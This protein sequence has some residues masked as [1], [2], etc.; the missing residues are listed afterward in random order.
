MTAAGR[1]A[2]R[3]NLIVLLV[4]CTALALGSFWVL[5]V[6]RHSMQ[7]TESVPARNAPDYFVD[8]FH[9]VRMSR[10]GQ[11]EYDISGKRMTHF[12][13]D[14][15]N[16]VQSPVV[17]SLASDRSPMSIQAQRAV[18][19]QNSSK[20]HL[21]DNVQLD[22]PATATSEHFHLTTDYLLLLPDD[23]IAKTDKPVDMTLGAARLKGIGMLANNA[24]SQLSLYGDVHA[25]YP[26]KGIATR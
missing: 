4:V 12:P 17:H 13:G 23:D 7:D 21:Y 15:T 24:T 9:Y 10:T 5:E 25:Y 8:D 11:P 22:R 26:P 20:V 3:F 2:G 16:E 18:V 1:A 6:M 19:D 14:D